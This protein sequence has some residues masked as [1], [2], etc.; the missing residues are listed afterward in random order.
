[1]EKNRGTSFNEQKDELLC[2]VYLEI[3]QDPI[4]SINQTLKKLWKKIEKTYN[5]KKNRELGN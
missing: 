5:E 3:P 1:M 4:A 2:H